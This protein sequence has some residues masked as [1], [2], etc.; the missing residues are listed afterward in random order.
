MAIQSPNFPNDYPD[1][2]NVSWNISVPAGMRILITFRNFSLEYASSCGYDKLEIIE[3]SKSTNY[4]GSALPPDYI[5]ERSSLVIRFVSDRSRTYSGFYLLYRGMERR[6][7]R[8]LKSF[9][10]VSVVYN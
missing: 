3:G 2:E 9:C 7:K 10:L 8:D 6:G 4:C 5:S 1:Y